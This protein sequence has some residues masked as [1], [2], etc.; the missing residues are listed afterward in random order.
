MKRE[1]LEWEFLEELN[2]RHEGGIIRQAER[3]RAV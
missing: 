2:G 3:A 1:E